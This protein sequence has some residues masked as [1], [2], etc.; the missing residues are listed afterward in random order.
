MDYIAPASPE[1]SQNMQSVFRYAK[2]KDSLLSSPN[3]QPTFETFS[4]I[5]EPLANHA[6]IDKDDI[7]V[8][9]PRLEDIIP[10]PDYESDLDDEDDEDDPDLNGDDFG[11]G[12]DSP[13]QEETQLPSD[14]ETLP[15]STQLPPSGPPK[16]YEYSKFEPKDHHKSRRDI[17]T[18]P[19]YSEAVAALTDLGTILR[20]KRDTGAGYKDPELDLWTRARLEGM[21]AMLRLF[22]GERSLTYMHWGPSAYQAAITM[23][24]GRHCARRLRELCRAYI[25]DRTVLP[26]NPYGDWN[27]SMLVDKNLCNEISIYLLSIGNEISAKKIVDFLR[28]EEIK[29]KYGIEK[30]I[31]HKTACRYL[32]T[33]GYRYKATPKGQYADGHE[34]EDVVLYRQNIF[35]PQWRRIQERMASWDEKLIESI[36]RGSGRRVITWFHDESIFYAHDRRKKGWYHK[37]APAKPYT[38]GEG[39]SLMVADFV[40]ADFGWLRSPDGKE[41]ARRLFK[42]GKNHDGYFSNEDIQNQAQVAMDILTKYYPQFDHVFVYDNATT[43]LKRAEDALSAHRMP[44]NIPKPGTNWG[45]EVIKRDPI[46][47]KPVCKPDGSA[48]KIKIQMK[49][50]QLPNGEVQQLY[51]PEGHPRAGV[52]KGMAI[53]LQERGYGNMSKKLAECKNF[54]C[55][56]GTKDC[57]CRR[58]LYNEPD[59]ANVDSILQMICSARGFQVLFLPKFHCELNFIEQC[60]GQAKSIYRTY[61]VSS[62]EDHLEANTITAL[63]SIP[64]SMMRKFANRSLRF[65]N[66]YDNGLNGR[67]AAWAS[68]KYKGHRVLPEGIMKELEEKGIF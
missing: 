17:F 43:H 60:W 19:S 39:A 14:Q 1:P 12:P 35:L 66:A 51:F 5:M 68:R 48:E 62:R 61:P 53:I 37:D 18:A 63:E 36:P 31:S 25:A 50:T 54:Q 21:Q 55:K 45:I 65:M 57:C 38:K 52:F 33:L 16:G 41:S 44:K 15:R 4:I 22:V 6:E 49:A 67:Q 27:E 8:D 20:P 13:V 40:S 9:M 23:G 24:H 26:V 7:Y 46:T 30:E 10:E 42:P 34:R 59:F 58:M 3:V 32:H 11:N 64:L 47:G 28:T 2:K 56:A 29:A